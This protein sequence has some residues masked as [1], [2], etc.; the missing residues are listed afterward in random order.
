MS[1]CRVHCRSPSTLKVKMQQRLTLPCSAVLRVKQLVWCTAA[2]PWPIPR[3]LWEASNLGGRPSCLCC[4]DLTLS[5]E[6][7]LTG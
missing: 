4:T 7:R 3:H 1:P 5:Q 2:D 6:I